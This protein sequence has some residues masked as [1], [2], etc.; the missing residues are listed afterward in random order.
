MPPAIAWQIV[1]H[2]SKRF[3]VVA[4][5]TSEYL[6]AIE[7]LTKLGHS[8]GMIYDALLLACARKVQ[9]T[10]IYTLNVKHFRLV[11]PDLADRIREP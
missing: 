5:T 4:L 7:A 1:N 9:A 11:A 6:A 2:T 8:G 10:R 3:R